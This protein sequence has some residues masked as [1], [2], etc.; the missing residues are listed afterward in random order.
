[1]ENPMDLHGK[2]PWENPRLTNFRDF[3]SAEIR[4]EHLGM[5]VAD[6]IKQRLPLM[7]TINI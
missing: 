7:P 4:T 5:A 6:S 2:I 3:P 1:M